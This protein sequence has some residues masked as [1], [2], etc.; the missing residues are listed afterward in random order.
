MF[1]LSVGR[2]KFTWFMTPDANSLKH[3]CS[4]SECA[5]QGVIPLYMVD[6]DIYRYLPS[7]IISTVDK[8]TALGFNSNFHNFLFGAEFDA[9][10]RV[11][12]KDKMSGL[13]LANATPL[14]SKIYQ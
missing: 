9:L 12:F 8:M 10:A 11:Y 4:N 2:R 6:N 3:I 7:V 1:V 14:T 13:R 5:S